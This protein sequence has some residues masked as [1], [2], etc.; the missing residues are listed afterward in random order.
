MNYS[1]ECR[2]NVNAKVIMVFC[3]ETMSVYVDVGSVRLE[4]IV[5][6][7]VTGGFLS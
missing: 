1:G 4:K 7:Q 5:R 2:G 6:T 3:G